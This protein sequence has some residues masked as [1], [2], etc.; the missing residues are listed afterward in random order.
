[1]RSLIELVRRTS[2]ELFLL[3]Q[4]LRLREPTLLHFTLLLLPML[5]TPVS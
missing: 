3:S 4:Q 2:E 1:M 5:D